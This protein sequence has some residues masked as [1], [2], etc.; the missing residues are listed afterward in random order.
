MNHAMYYSSGYFVDD[1][2]W[3]DN[4]AMIAEFADLFIDHD[5]D[6]V[7]SGHNH[8]MEY[9]NNSGVVYNIIGGFGGH[10]DPDYTT[11]VGQQGTGSVWYLSGQHGY[12]DVEINGPIANVTFRNPEY[13]VVQNYVI[14][15]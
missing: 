9:L 8:H 10:L 4:K 2:G 13:A 11:K 1:E 6:L 7:F 5:I 3:W 15:E 14:T 12:L